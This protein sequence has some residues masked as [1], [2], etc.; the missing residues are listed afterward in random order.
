MCCDARHKNCI[1]FTACKKV[2]TCLSASAIWLVR[3]SS[4]IKAHVYPIIAWLADGWT[5]NQ[6]NFLAYYIHHHNIKVDSNFSPP[7]DLTKETLE[8]QRTSALLSYGFV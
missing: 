8:L 4:F 3:S 6:L 5:D 1:L 7:V 2:K